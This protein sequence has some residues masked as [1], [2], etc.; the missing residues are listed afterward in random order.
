VPRLAPRTSRQLGIG[1]LDELGGAVA[2]PERG[3]ADFDQYR[4]GVGCE[5]GLDG[6]KALTGVLDRRAREYAQKLITAD[7]NDQVI[8]AQ[9]GTD[10]AHCVLEHPV[11]GGMTVHIVDSLQAD[12]VDIGKHER[13][14]RSA[15]TI[16]LVVKF[17]QSWP[18]QARP[19]ELVDLSHGQLLDQR[20][21]VC[22][23]LCP[24]LGGLVAISGCL[25]AVCRRA[26]STLCRGAAVSGCILAVPRRA[27]S[28]LRICRRLP[29]VR[30]TSLT[31]RQFAI[32]TRG[33]L[34]ALQRCQIAVVR[35][36]IASGSPLETCMCGLLA[37]L[38]TAI[39][40]LV[41]GIVQLR[42]AAVFEFAIAGRLIALGRR[43]IALGRRLIALGRRLIGVGR[44]LIA[45]GRGLIAVSERLVRIRER[46]L[47]VSERLTVR[48]CP[49]SR[50]AALLP[51]VDRLI[52]LIRSRIAWR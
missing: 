48:G 38:G 10:P 35:R 32:A 15:S 18:A 46:L 47:A 9:M 17:D 6:R 36:L 27:Q 25:F 30:R 8:G 3:E 11:A 44:G 20:V 28:V 43:L 40:N 42:V 37:L 41:G 4:I 16:D 26:D 1:A 51:S 34:I 31:R 19:S 29:A 39:P 24:V 52:V 49:S 45:V 23:G 50:G 7:A 12:D 21:T 5:H 33:G 14:A 22:A 13:S 2:R